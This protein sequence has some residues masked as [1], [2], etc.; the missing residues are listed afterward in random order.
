MLNGKPRDC[1]GAKGD[2][3]D[4]R[5]TRHGNCKPIRPARVIEE[6]LISSKVGLFIF[7]DLCSTGLA[8]GILTEVQGVLHLQHTVDWNRKMSQSSEK[9]REGMVGRGLTGL[10]HE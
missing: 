6:S 10:S 2:F 8:R 4:A 1:N 7:A 3:G 5:D 9:R